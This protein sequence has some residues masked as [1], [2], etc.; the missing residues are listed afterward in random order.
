MTTRKER[1]RVFAERTEYDLFEA[2]N[3]GD[4]LQVKRL[5]EENGIDVNSQVIIYLK[6]KWINE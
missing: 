1:R 5:I 2:C 4:L 6:G 3:L